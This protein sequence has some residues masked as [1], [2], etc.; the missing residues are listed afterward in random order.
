MKAKYKTL[1]MV[2]AILSIHSIKAQTDTLLD[3]FPL[4]VGNLWTY[5][6]RTRDIEEDVT[7]SDSGSAYYTV[8][9]RMITLDSTRWLVRERRDIIHCINYWPPTPD[10]CFLRQD[11]STFELIENHQGR[12]HLYRNR[13][14]S[15]VWHS[16]FPFGYDLVDTT[17]VFRYAKVDSTGVHKFRTR[18]SPFSLMQYDFAFR[19]NVGGVSCTGRSLP[20]GN[21]LTT[22]HQLLNSIIVAVRDPVNAEPHEFALHQN[23]PNPFNPSTNIGFRIVDFGSVSLKVFDVLGAEIATLVNEE[24]KP[25]NYERVFDASGLASGVYLYRLTAGGFV[26]TRKLI[27]IR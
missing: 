16:V 5:D 24:M 4:A 25:G 20:T 2:C 10:T 15:E 6:Y 27:V 22:N 26:Q 12:H 13:P 17:M 1:L 18:A 11:S 9:D 8:L 21:S 19:R 3:V 14:H 23:Y 7:F